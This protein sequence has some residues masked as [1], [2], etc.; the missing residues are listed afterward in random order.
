[1]VNALWYDVIF[2]SVPLYECFNVAMYEIIWGHEEV[3]LLFILSDL[4]HTYSS[5][6]HW[7]LITY[8]STLSLMV[9]KPSMNTPK[10]RPIEGYIREDIKDVIGLFLGGDDPR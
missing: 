10:N 9:L 3:V 5:G 1:M 6:Y 2:V 4:I 7:R 8:L